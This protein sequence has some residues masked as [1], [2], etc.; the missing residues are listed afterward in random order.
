MGVLAHRT[1]YRGHP[2]RRFT[3]KGR[4][5][6]ID[7]LFPTLFPPGAKHAKPLALLRFAVRDGSIGVSRRF[8]ASGLFP[9]PL[10]KLKK[11]TYYES[12]SM[13]KCFIR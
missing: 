12:P 13:K 11:I 8:N 1:N 3:H 4:K 10:I 5:Q 9:K 7:A 2:V 6:T